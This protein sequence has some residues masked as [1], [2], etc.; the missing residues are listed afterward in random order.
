MCNNNNF[1]NVVHLISEKRETIICFP[2]LRKTLYKTD[3]HKTL[4]RGLGRQ[5]K[6]WRK[7][8]FGSL[9]ASKLI[10]T[11]A[12]D[13]T[14]QFES[15]FRQFLLELVLIDSQNLNEIIAFNFVISERY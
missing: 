15:C 3:Q 9:T 11:S 5:L 10:C 4:D 12:L 1:E 7:G 2:E 14:L 6:L 8:G 13:V